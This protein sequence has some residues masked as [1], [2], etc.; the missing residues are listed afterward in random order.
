MQLQIVGFEYCGKEGTSQRRI[1]DAQKAGRLIR[2]LLT[3]I[4][5]EWEAN[6]HIEQANYPSRKTNS[7]DMKHAACA[8]YCTTQVP[9]IRFRIKYNQTVIVLCTYTNVLRRFV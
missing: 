2:T 9:V 1:L 3:V 4:C 6:G 7:V 5:S 8:H